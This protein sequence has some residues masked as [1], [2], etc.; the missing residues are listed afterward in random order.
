MNIFQHLNAENTETIRKQISFGRSR[1]EAIIRAL[2]RE[3]DDFKAHR[4]SEDIYSREDLLELLDYLTSCIRS[5]VADDIE[6][7]TNTGV[8]AVKQV[9][10]NAQLK[11]LDI[12]LDITDLDDQ[13]VLDDMKRLNLDSMANAK[14]NFKLTSFTDD[15]KAMK[16]VS[17]RLEEDNNILQNEVS[18]LRSK[19]NQTEQL[20][21]EVA[22][23]KSEEV[24]HLQGELM[25]AK[26]EG[27]KKV[28]ETNQFRN[29]QKIMQSQ[30]S[31]I[32]ELRRQLQKYE[33]DLCKEED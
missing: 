15:A 7:I 28:K 31:Q 29:M 17:S 26:E 3:F 25:N 1:K 33:P 12:P 2:E 19:L 11:G 13:S 27:N 9:L 16:E 20:Y 22:Q 6:N 5:Q 32:K 14:R 21:G 4:L 8:L 10:E 18:T 24:R 23:S 30:A